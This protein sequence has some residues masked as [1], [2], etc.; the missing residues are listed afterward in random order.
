MKDKI[1]FPNGGHY[2]GVEG[3]LY[4]IY[5]NVGKKKYKCQVQPQVLLFL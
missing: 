2:K 4:T 3:S 5:I 1:S